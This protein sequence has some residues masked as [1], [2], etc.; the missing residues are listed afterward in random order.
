MNNMM[1][2]LA[3]V[4]LGMAGSV[5]AIRLKIPVGGIL[6]AMV[7]AVLFN[8]ITGDKA[9]FYNQVKVLVQ[10]TVGTISGSRIGRR[11]FGEMKKVLIPMCIIFPLFLIYNLIFGTIIY[12]TS[13]LDVFTSFY[14]LSPGSIADIAIVAGELGA[15]TA[16]VGLV[17]ALRVLICSAVMPPIFCAML[18][19]YGKGEKENEI[20]VPSSGS[21][22]AK[23][24]A[25]GWIIVQ[26]VVA[27]VGGLLLRETGVKGGAIIGAMFFSMIFTCIFGKT[28]MP[29]WIKQCQQTMVGTYVGAGITM[30]TLL[31]ATALIW[32]IFLL[33]ISIVIGTFIS[34]WIVMKTKTLDPVSAM[35]CC[36]PGG[37]TEMLILTDELGG[38]MPKVAVVHSIRI[39]FVISIFPTVINWFIGHF[40]F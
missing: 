6:G 14:S 8:V 31:N 11:D 29:Q 10:L 18:K 16:V 39:F 21:E 30:A 37:M 19:K 28:E 15:D 32:P 38:D 26:F 34:T 35:T 27:A 17:H 1:W 4:L 9:F 2:F 12:K 33:F 25:P 13:E 22:Q 3:T 36:A 20:K 5:V 7:M 24:K 40:L 23:K